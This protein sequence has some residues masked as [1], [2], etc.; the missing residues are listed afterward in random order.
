[1]AQGRHQDGWDS[2][3]SSSLQGRESIGTIGGIV[4]DPCGPY[5]PYAPVLCAVIT[6]GPRNMLWSPIFRP[7][8]A[9]SRQTHRHACLRAERGELP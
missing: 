4:T 6:C 2:D 5:D 3:F 8:L 7:P 1:M 9:A